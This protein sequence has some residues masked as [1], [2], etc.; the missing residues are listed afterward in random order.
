MFLYK[1]GEEGDGDGQF[2]KPSGLAII[3]DLI[4]VA[5]KDNRRIQILNLKGR[6][7]SKFGTMGSG[8]GSFHYPWGVAVNKHRQIAVCDTKNARVQSY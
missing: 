5:D 7:V 4:F 3:D 6:F 1:F 8:S 2:K